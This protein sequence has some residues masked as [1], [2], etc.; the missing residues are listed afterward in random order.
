MGGIRWD[1]VKGHTVLS[2]GRNTGKS[3]RR[4]RKN[5]DFNKAYKRHSASGPQLQLDGFPKNHEAWTKE[6]SREYRDMDL[7]KIGLEFVDRNGLVVGLSR[8]SPLFKVYR[9]VGKR[10]FYV[11]P[12]SR[13][14]QKRL[15]LKM[16]DIQAWAVEEPR[17]EEH[18]RPRS[19]EKAEHASTIKVVFYGRILQPSDVKHRGG[20]FC[21]QT[22]RHRVSRARWHRPH[23]PAY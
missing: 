12:P 20:G 3:K 7:R 15:A 16:A 4:F 2:D 5:K 19:S 6:P 11:P 8:N 10:K 9:E 14:D 1:Q 22:W 17:K 18:E 13:Q 21:H 23:R